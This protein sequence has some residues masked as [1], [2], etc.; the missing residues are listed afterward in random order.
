MLETL[1]LLYFVLS[2]PGE[3][4]ILGSSS[5][6]WVPV[7]QVL[8]SRSFSM[9]T[10]YD[11]PSVNAVFKDNI[12]L[13]LRYM[14]GDVKNKEE[15]NWEEVVEPFHFETTLQAGEGFAF[16]DQILAEYKD[17][18]VKTTNAHFNFQ[19]GFKTDGF[20]YGDGVCHLA[21]LI[22]WAAKDAGLE[23]VYFANHNFA[24]INEVPKEYGVS[25][26][27]DPGN[28]ANG[29]RQNLYIFNSYDHPVTFV[30]EYDGTNLTISVLE[31]KNS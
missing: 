6:A 15:I 23:T 10:R 3:P 18:I 12:L 11:V 24:K 4:S 2:K 19:D 30:F 25:I 31:A 5:V 9:E 28:F 13:A 29:S 14:N 20:L 26:R 21:S 7:R 22:Y 27:F 8:A 16:H 1:I 17:K